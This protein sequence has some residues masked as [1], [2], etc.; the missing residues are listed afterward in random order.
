MFV[1]SIILM[2]QSEDLD[3]ANAEPNDSGR[4]LREKQSVL[5]ESAEALSK[6]CFLKEG[7]AAG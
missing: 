4:S 3:C 1:Q 7:T 6:N 5:A 2:T